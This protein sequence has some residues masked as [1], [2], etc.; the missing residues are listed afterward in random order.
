MGVALPTFVPYTF[1]YRPTW[2]ALYR[3]APW[4]QGWALTP[5]ERDYC[6]YWQQRWHDRQD[7][8]TVE[9]DVIV[10]PDHIRQLEECPEDWCMFAPIG[11][12]QGTFCVVRF[13]QAFIDR[14]PNLWDQAL[15]AHRTTLFQ[16]LW[17]VLDVWA[18]EHC[19]G[20]QHIHHWPPYQNVR[21]ALMAPTRS[22]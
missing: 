16:P 10:E 13:R 6:Y 21:P 22:A 14:H 18:Y 3:A 19:P 12:L 5:D 2:D 15:A 7:F 8:I 4:F 20:E 9:H 17:T 11:S 1:F